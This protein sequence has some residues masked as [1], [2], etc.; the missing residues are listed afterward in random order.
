[1][2]ESF[3]IFSGI[4]A[5]LS[6]LNEWDIK[7]KQKIFWV[8]LILL[9]FFD[10]LR[11]E[12][13]TDWLSYNDC[14][15]KAN[16]YDQPG[17]EPGFMLYT[18][19]IKYFTDNYSTYL[20]LTTASIYIGIFYSVFKITN[21]SLLSVFYLTGSIP[22]YSGSLRQMMASI[23]FTLALNAVIERKLKKYF[24]L[25]VTGVLFHVTNIAFMPMYWLFGVSINIFLFIY[26]FLFVIAGVIGTKFKNLDLL[27][28]MVNPNKSIIG[29]IGGSLADSNPELGF[30]R[31]GITVTGYF[32]FWK[33]LKLPN[34]QDKSKLI[35]IN[36]FLYMT[37]FTLMFY[38]IGTYFIS[39]VSSRLDIYTGLISA[40]VLIGLLETSYISKQSKILLFT[41][42]VFLL[43][44]IYSR[45]AFMDLFHPYSSIFY[46]YEYH[47]DLY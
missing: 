32:Y 21:Y 40:S 1:M 3:T 25:M 31:K 30:I 36:F 26:I 28:Q 41:F 23:F 8:L 14:F 9:I 15:N 6:I 16:L 29:R 11:W 22:W 34:N 38:Y 47:R 2:I 12:M 5:L 20:F 24:I 17:M 37:S 18:R 4:I 7:T 27:L 19:F 10:G 45:L 33:R 44:V 39:M 43:G 35:T 13:G 42:V 46:N